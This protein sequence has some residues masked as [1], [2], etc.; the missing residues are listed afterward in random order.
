MMM[1][2]VVVLMVVVMVVV[3]VVSVMMIVVMI[4]VVMMVVALMVMVVKAPLT[5]RHVQVSGSVGACPFFLP[6]YFKCPLSLPYFSILD[7]PMS[8]Y[9]ARLSAIGL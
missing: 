9:F 8:E 3:L 7:P 1:V 5:G 6:N 2:V 4:M